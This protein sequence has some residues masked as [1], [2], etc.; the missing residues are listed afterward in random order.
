MPSVSRQIRLPALH[1]G[2]T[3]VTTTDR[4]L[5]SLALSVSPP[6]PFCSLRPRSSFTSRISCPKPAFLSRSRDKAP[7]GPRELKEGAIKSGT[8][9][10]KWL[11]LDRTRSPFHP[12]SGPKDANFTAAQ[13]CRERRRTRG[14]AVLSRLVDARVVSPL[15]NAI[16]ETMNYSRTCRLIVCSASTGRKTRRIPGR[17]ATLIR[18]RRL[19]SASPLYLDNVRS[20]ESWA[21][22]RSVLQSAY[23]D[24][25]ATR[26]N[27]FT[28]VRSTSAPARLLLRFRSSLP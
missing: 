22:L 27:K 17:C 21:H 12:S 14:R 2:S 5:S 1:F 25:V 9:T 23:P 10:Q 16:V 15:L 6:S 3:S 28:C 18:F 24:E 19:A 20:I 11:D 7:S 13:L 26:T 8:R 4:D